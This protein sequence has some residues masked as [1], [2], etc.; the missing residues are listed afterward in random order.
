MFA[1][2]LR[3]LADV[4]TLNDDWSLYKTYVKEVEIRDYSAG[5]HYTR[6]QRRRSLYETT[7]Q[8]VAIRDHSAGGRYTRP[9]CRRSIYETIVHAIRDHGAGG[10]YV[11]PRCRRSLYETTAQEVAIRDHGA[12]GRY[13]RPR[14]RR[15]LYETTVQEVAIRDH[16]AGG[17]YMRPQCRRSLYET[18]VPE[19]AIRD[20]SAVVTPSSQVIHCPQ[21]EWSIDHRKA[22]LVEL[23]GLCTGYQGIRKSSTYFINFSD[24]LKGNL[25]NLQNLLSGSLENET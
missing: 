10:R 19:V 7:V 15:S 1:S 24:N 18:T 23:V 6:P 17:R 11:R 13:T 22:D 3:K 20:H 8:E 2:Q 21:A 16:S 12:G 9:Q 25:L 5:G 4:C 14:C